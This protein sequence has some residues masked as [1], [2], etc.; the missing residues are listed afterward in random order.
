MRLSPDKQNDLN[1]LLHQARKF[2]FKIMAY[3]KKT[4]DSV[5]LVRI[6]NI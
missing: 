6:L 4:I 1:Q 3:D 5:D 2:Y